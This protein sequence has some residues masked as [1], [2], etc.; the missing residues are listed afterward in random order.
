MLDLEWWMIK[1]KLSWNLELLTYASTKMLGRIQKLPYETNVINK[2]PTNTLISVIYGV[3]SRSQMGTGGLGRILT[4]KPF[5]K[6][7]PASTFDI[8]FKLCNR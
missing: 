5:A 7:M 3:Y 1:T 4:L 2:I 8:S 6:V